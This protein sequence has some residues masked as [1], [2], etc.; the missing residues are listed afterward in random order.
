MVA[1]LQ[2]MVIIEC[3]RIGIKQEYANTCYYNQA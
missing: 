2:Y 3:N 1:H